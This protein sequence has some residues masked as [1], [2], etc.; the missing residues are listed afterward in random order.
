ME[1][2]PK[3]PPND[4]IAT[5]PLVGFWKD[6]VII[7]YRCEELSRLN[8]EAYNRAFEATQAVAAGAAVDVPPLPGV[9][10]QATLGLPTSWFYT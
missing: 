1:F 5:Y 7:R 10:T 9:S 6:R 4:I 2:G 3:V 8:W